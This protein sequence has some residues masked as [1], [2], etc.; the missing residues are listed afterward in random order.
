VVLLLSQMHP[1]HK[2]TPY[3]P[4]IH[5]NI[6]FPSTPRSL[7]FRFTYLLTPWCRILFENLI[8][9]LSK[10]ILSL[11]N[12]KVHH[13]VHKSSPLDPILSQ[14]NPVRSCQRISPGPKR[15]ETFRNNRNFYGEGLLAP[16]ATPKLEDHPLS[17]VRGCL[18]NIF[19]ATLRNW[20]TSSIRNLSTRHVVGPTQHGF[21]SGFPTK[22]L[23]TFIMPVMRAT[24]PIHLILDLITLITSGEVYKLWSFS[25]CSFLQPPATSFPSAKGSNEL[26]Y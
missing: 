18:F 14:L 26:I 1:V 17:A 5:S 15:F 11:W 22:I 7:P 20:R 8:V 19:A 16:R 13:R 21:L 3:F 9:S 12:P 24:L 4:K 6:I 2:L 23:N 10:H 25:L